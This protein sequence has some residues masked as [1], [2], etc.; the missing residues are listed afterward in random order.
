ML[1]VP[2]QY[3]QHCSTAAVARGYAPRPPRLRVAVHPA[4]RAPTRRT[5][6]R[7]HAELAGAR[8]CSRACARACVCERL[9]ERARAREGVGVLEEGA[10]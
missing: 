1:S 3:T 2:R 6:V 10:E 9:R 7:A 5:C 8:V 4:A